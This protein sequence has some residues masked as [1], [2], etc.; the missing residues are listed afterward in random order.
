MG[1]RVPSSRPP[2]SPCTAKEESAMETKE[3]KRS[4]ERERRLRLKR[5]TMEDAEGHEIETYGII[6]DLDDGRGHC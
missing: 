5:R 1:E 6:E 3:A 4:E 2:A